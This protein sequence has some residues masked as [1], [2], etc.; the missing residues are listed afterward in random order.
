MSVAFVPL[1][2]I[3]KHKPEVLADRGV[4]FTESR[5]RHSL[6]GKLRPEMDAPT[7][8]RR[9]A[10][11]AKGGRRRLESEWV[12]IPLV[13]VLVFAVGFGLKFFVG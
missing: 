4:V 6:Q 5:F 11:K 3:S 12:V 1:W 9:A 13:I 8:T 10:R 7:S 2:T